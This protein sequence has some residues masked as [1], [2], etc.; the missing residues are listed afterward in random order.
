MTGKAIDPDKTVEVDGV[1][2][3]L[4]CGGCLAKAT[5]LTGDELINL[6]F[7]DTTKGFEKAK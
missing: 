3:G 6:L 1:K 7:T 4:C 2:V 5:K